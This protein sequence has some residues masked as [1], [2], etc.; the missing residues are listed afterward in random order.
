MSR[1]SIDLLLLALLCLPGQLCLPG[2]A[3]ALESDRQQPIR[4]QADRVELDNRRGISSYTGHV[5][6]DQGSL[7]VEADRLVVYRQGEALARIEADGE[8]VRFRQRPDNATEDIAGSARHIEYR[9]ADNL[10]V[11]QGAAS[12][13]KGGDHFSGERIEYDTRHAVVNA[14]GKG[15]P[16]SANGTDTGSGD[17]RVHAIIQ[18]R[19]GAPAA[20]GESK[21]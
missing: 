9:A 7:H 15:T 16:E 10:I 11:L 20:N 6:V 2:L 8:P 5:A 12:V 13:Q 4:I 3:S 14:S 18:P 17:G 19:N 21:P 1:R